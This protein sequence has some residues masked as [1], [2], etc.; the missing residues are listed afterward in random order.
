MPVLVFAALVVATFAAF[1]VT[2]RL[3]RAA[4]VIEQLTFRRT[5]AAVVLLV[6]IVGFRLWRR[7]RADGE[8]FAA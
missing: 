8:A 6:A 4:P 2:T 7:R 5:I 1:F 3:K